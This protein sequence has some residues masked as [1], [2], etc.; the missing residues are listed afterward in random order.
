MRMLLIIVQ[1]T[2]GENTLTV[3][4]HEKEADGFWCERG[5]VGWD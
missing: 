5:E 3:Q 2:N 4:L 1:V